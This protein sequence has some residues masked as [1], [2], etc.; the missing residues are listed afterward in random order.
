MHV[1]IIQYSV[2]YI[3]IITVAPEIIIPPNNMTVINGSEVVL[4]CTVV[5]NPLPAISWFVVGGVNLS[6]LMSNGIRIP[7]D[8]QGRISDSLINNMVLNSTSILSSMRLP[9]TAPFVAGEYACRA[10]NYLRSINRT[11]TLTIYGK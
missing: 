11:A 8:N 5:G 9:E 3:V 7:F 1:I 4:N 10:S 6:L 2:H